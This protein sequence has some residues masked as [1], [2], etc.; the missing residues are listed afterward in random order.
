MNKSEF[1][2]HKIVLETYEWENIWWENT[3]ESVHPR[4]L[5]VGDSISCGIRTKATAASNNELLFDGVGT[6]KALDNAFFYSTIH[7]FALQ[8]ESCAAVL[9]N[10]GLHGWHLDDG[11][12]EFYYQKMIDFLKKEFCDIPSALVLTTDV[13]N[14]PY[15]YDAKRIISRNDIVCRLAENNE[16]PVIDLYSVSRGLADLHCDDGVHFTDE[17]YGK[18]GKALFDET[19]KFLCKK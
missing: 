11:E 19:K 9:F 4:V 2:N 10:N 7:N 13:V 17:G 15:G 1:F 6:S 8:Q 3:A 5:Y 18:L 12:Y 16:M 14:E